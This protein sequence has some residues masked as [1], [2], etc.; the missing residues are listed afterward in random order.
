MRTSKHEINIQIYI[1]FERKKNALF[2]NF[3]KGASSEM[4]RILKWSLENFWPWPSLHSRSR[5]NILE[6]F[7]I[8][9]MVT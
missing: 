9:Y 8:T 2:L 1:F 6:L 3:T 7:T 5:M 4:W